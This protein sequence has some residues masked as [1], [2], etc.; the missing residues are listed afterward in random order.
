MKTITQRIVCGRG[1]HYFLGLAMLLL[2]MAVPQKALSQDCIASAQEQCDDESPIVIQLTAGNEFEL[3]VI[4]D[5]LS[6]EVEVCSTDNFMIEVYHSL[7]GGDTLITDEDVGPDF[8]H[9]DGCP[10]VG[11]VL[12][13]NLLYNT[14]S[15]MV[16][17]C[18]RQVILLPRIECADTTL[19]CNH[20]VFEDPF[21][22]SILPHEV[23]CD[24]FD[25]S[26]LDMQI[27]HTEWANMMLMDTLFRV[28]EVSSNNGKG[29][30]TCIDTIIR[31]A[32]PLAEIIFPSDDTVF[33]EL[34]DGTPPNP[35]LSGLP[36]LIEEA[37][38]DTIYLDAGETTHCM[39]VSY[40]D[41]AW[42]RF[43]CEMEK[44]VRVWKIRTQEGMRVDTQM[45]TILDNQG[46]QGE[47]RFTPIDSTLTLINGDTLNIPVY[48]VSSSSHGCTS[49][50]NL[51][52]LYATD[53]CAGVAKV[54]VSVMDEN[55][56][57]HSL[58]NGGPFM[59]FRQ[60]KYLVTYTAAD[61]CWNESYFYVWVQVRD[62]VNPVML[63][64]DEYNIS[65]SGEVTWLDLEEFV[66]HHVTDNCGLELVVGRR[67]GDHATTCGA[68]DSTS[69]V[70]MY[71]Q[72][73]RMWL[74]N[75]G[76][77]CT[78]LVDVDSGW[79]DRI[80]FCCAD[81]GSEIMI[82]ILA[83]D[84]SC[85]VSRGMTVIVPVDKGGATIYER[86]PDVTL[87]CEAWNENYQ[88]LIFP[89]SASNEPNL[90]SLDKYFG[91]YLPYTTGTTPESPPISIEDINCNVID[92]IMVREETV[93]NS[94]N[95]LYRA[96]CAG[97]LTQN[98]TLIYDP[99]C[100][101]F[102]IRRE[103]LVNGGVIAVQYI[104]TEIRC[105]FVPELFEYPDNQDTMIT[106]AD[107][108]ILKNADYWT[109]NRFNLETIGPVYNGS[110]CRVVAIGYFDKLMD[111][112][113]SSNPNEADAVIIRTWC[114][115]DWCTSDLGPDWQSSLGNDGILMWTQNIK[116]FV[117]PDSP[118]V[119]IEKVGVVPPE[120]VVVTP[121]GE[122][123]IFEVVG[124]IRTED[125]LNVNNVTVELK[126]SNLQDQLL[127]NESG[128][129]KLQVDEGS[130]VQITPVKKGD[131]GNGLS[132][133]DLI[134]I[135]R[136]ML[137][138]QLITS[139]YKLIAADVNNDNKLTPADILYLRRVIL[140]K[141]DG[142]S[143]PVSWKFV[144]AKYSFTNPKEAYA[145]NYPTALDIE[146]V[147]KDISSEF[148]AIKLGDVN[149]S[150]NVSRSSNR[151]NNPVTAVEILDRK[152]QAGDVVEVP[153][154]MT[155]AIRMAG[156]QFALKMDSRYMDI[157]E[158]SKANI[159]LD[160]DHWVN[161]DGEL[162]L[163]WADINATTVSPGD[164]LITVTVQVHQTGALRDLIS[165]NTNTMEAEVYDDKDQIRSL[166]LKFTEVKD[167]SQ[168]F[169]VSQ[170]RPNPVLNE[171]IIEYTLPRDARVQL[172]IHDVTG[173]LIYAQE[174]TATK[175]SN[176]FRVHTTQ[177]Q[178]GVMYYTITD[179]EHTATRKM[180]VIR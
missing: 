2:S 67:V 65:M 137:R 166:A 27:I 19:L 29:T 3:R 39:V 147:N 79:L 121:P 32:I 14:G 112:I 111:M 23:G 26:T 117:D 101:T 129:F 155:E 136:H 143:D 82:E 81:L 44:Y 69:L 102:S 40:T 165:L 48:G 146:R 152:V 158:V 127:T 10:Y 57:V 116:I 122:K 114:M 141:L 95:G 144:D 140:N 119:A 92:G 179:G 153:I 60:G 89:D 42:G 148:V 7:T 174:A 100:N 8:L 1:V 22:E 70:G 113:S 51:P 177:L 16:D 93:I 11:K 142:I 36:F 33:C 115:A 83:I 125:A 161:D 104:R 99:G 72:K 168:S 20:P 139:P 103:F 97:E 52:V 15:A 55:N 34:W 25:L 132:T 120:D 49:D 130:R 131:L 30:I 63:L 159:L 13:A 87:A 172:M 53:D 28:W 109:G 62:Y 169:T 98:A 160:E 173:K 38:G 31:E 138:K 54:S 5:F 163:S 149:Q 91:T 46:P 171:T 175:G 45:I 74:E 107:I 94:Y 47:F 56:V 71:R 180:V 24:S 134:L 167:Q 75:D 61:S 110:D 126:T 162:R 6:V 59:G 78:D 37:S 58:T 4:G 150:V 156:I 157:L 68:D 105:P 145:E 151:S 86:L 21:N 18:T 35:S 77:N 50:G 73:Y 80:P 43:D 106:I 124:Q 12:Y 118:D 128:S 64:G 41:E 164:E 108:S 76:W 84:R 17:I 85:N 133:L 154:L 135:Q 96:S 170:N 90:D 9:A 66:S 176:Q 178:S 123:T 88:D